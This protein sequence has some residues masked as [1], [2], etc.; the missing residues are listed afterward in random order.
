MECA[1]N[2]FSAQASPETTGSSHMVSRPESVDSPG[3]SLLTHFVS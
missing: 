2:S 3:L 1:C